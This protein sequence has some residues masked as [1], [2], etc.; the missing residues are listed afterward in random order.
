MPVNPRFIW[1]AREHNPEVAVG[2]GSFTTVAAALGASGLVETLQGDGPFTVCA[3]TDEAAL[4]GDWTD[5]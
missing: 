2:A 3:P 1:G 4:L 5:L